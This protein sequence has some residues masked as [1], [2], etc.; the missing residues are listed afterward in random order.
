[1]LLPVYELIVRSVH[2]QVDLQVNV[3]VESHVLAGI[4]IQLLL[5]SLLWTVFVI[6]IFK[7]SDYSHFF[8]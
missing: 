8:V 5:C 2:E 7:V 3:D 4:S 1:M 6:Y